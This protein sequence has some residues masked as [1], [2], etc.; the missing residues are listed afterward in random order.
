MAV[1]KS[2]ADSSCPVAR[3]LDIVGDRWA[4]LIVRDAFD[5]VRRFGQF[6]E[7]L[8]IARNI[9]TDR[10]RRLVEAGVL[11]VIP[12]SD[13][14]AYQEYILTPKGEALFPVI[15]TLRQWGEANL[16]RRGEKRSQLL[17]RTSGKPVPK[18]TLR[19]QGGEMLAPADT[20]VKK[21]AVRM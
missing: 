6:Q 18:L 3:A 11:E 13:G 1:R 9:L 2:L 4:L 7:N 5:G 21:V 10:L 14:S 19:G 12:A 20:F 15:V 17:D 16:F 8:E